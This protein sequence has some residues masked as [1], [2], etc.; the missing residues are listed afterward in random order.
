MND[1]EDHSESANG[2]ACNTRRWRRDMRRRYRRPCGLYR[3]C[4]DPA[5]PRR[6]MG[7]VV[8]YY[9][10][11]APADGSFTLDIYAEQCTTSASCSAQP[12]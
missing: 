3:R 6:R 1:T 4:D 11:S 10:S 2:S 12:Q 5:A 9:A 8:D 7:V